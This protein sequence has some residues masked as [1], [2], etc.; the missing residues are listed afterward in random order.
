[1]AQENLFEGIFRSLNH[2]KKAAFLI[3]LLAI[4]ATTLFHRAFP[5]L[6]ESHSLLRVLSSDDT[7]GSSLA[8]SMNGILSQKPLILEALKNEGLEQQVKNPGDFFSIEDAGPGLVK[9]S[10]KHSNPAVLKELGDILIKILSEKYLAYSSEAD[11][12]EIEAL[13]MKKNAILEKMKSTKAEMESMTNPAPNPESSEHSGLEEE[14]RQVELKLEESRQR[15]ATIPKIRVVASKEQT[16]EFSAL[17]EKLAKSRAYLAELLFTYREK[18]PRVIKANAEI[19]EIETNLKS[20]SSKKDREEPNPQYEAALKEVNDLELKLSD[21]RASLENEKNNRILATNLKAAEIQTLQ[22][23]LKA[24]ENLHNEIVLKLEQLNLKRMTSIGKIQVLKKDKEPP[25]PL[26]LSLAQREFIGLLSGTLF[27]II[28]LYTPAPF[29][30]EAERIKLSNTSLMGFG[31]SFPEELENFGGVMRVPLLPHNKAGIP[32]QDSCITKFDERLI[33]LNEP[34][35]RQLG[36]LKALLSNLQIQFAETGCRILMIS[37]ARNGMGRTTL[38]SNLAILLAQ[39]GYSVALVDANFRKPALHRVFELE[40][41]RGFS[42]AI[43]GGPD[44]DLIQPTMV[45]NLGVITSG[46]IPPNPFELVSNFQTK[47][48]LDSL[49]RRFEVV[50]VDAPGLLDFPDA[51]ILA[52]HVEGIIFLQR[53]GELEKDSR[54]SKEFLKKLQTKILAFVQT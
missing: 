16:R 11:K 33:V 49:K 28:L 1:M 4:L 12:F 20:I 52:S 37:S 2:N 43:S 34:N 26:G 48:F 7:S 31:P 15:L 10:V 14:I 9:L 13:E 27:A 22:Q 53:E 25:R 41:N 42:T 23:R 6:Y 54:A 17:K 46:P 39:E 51:R 18:H 3:I 29:K 24:L 45:K 35:S 19:S 5:T 36:P 21:L 38:V 8:S 44:F 40:N 30:I 32:I 50:L 47:N